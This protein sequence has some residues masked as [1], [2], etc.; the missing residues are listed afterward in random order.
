[1]KALRRYGPVGFVV[2]LHVLA[3]LFVLSLPPPGHPTPLMM[4][5]IAI[6]FAQTGLVAVWVAV[7]R[8]RYYVR[9]PLALAG[10]GWTWLALMHLVDPSLQDPESA[11][12]LILGVLQFLYVAGALVLG[13][14]LAA[15]LRR[16]STGASPPAQFGLAALMIWTAM[17]AATLAAARILV[18]ALGWTT[19]VFQWQYLGFMPIFAAYNAAYALAAF[20]SVRVRKHR[21]GVI[22]STAVLIGLAGATL[23]ATFYA[24]FQETGGIT[25]TECLELAAFQAGLLYATLIP[26]GWREGGKPQPQPDRNADGQTQERIA[27]PPSGRDCG[28][29]G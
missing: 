29:I 17:V 8:V 13:R 21:V 3:G 25:A 11:A 15:R 19:E 18:T 9:F 10:I 23:P 5:A 14:L 27:P 26:L 7:S 24:I 22:L 12:W 1:M 2:L 28:P 16:R 6:S 4:L 20:V